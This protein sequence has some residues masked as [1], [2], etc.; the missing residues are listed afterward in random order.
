MADVF[1]REKRSEVM[2]R[3]RGKHTRPELVV[4]SM[5][6]RMGYRFRLHGKDLPGTPDV[7]LP[8]HK[9]V[10]DIRGCFWHLC[11]KCFRG[12]PESNRGFWMSKL[13]RNRDRDA[14]NDD[15]LRELGWKV[16][17]VWEHELKKA[18]RENLAERL[19]KEIGK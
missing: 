3:I 2:S 4:R 14:E 17:V 19:R 6:H 13:K 11:P 1:T 12:Y 7:V 9:T 5:L 18:N 15:G 8:R 10:V 16:V